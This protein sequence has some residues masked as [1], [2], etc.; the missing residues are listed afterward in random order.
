MPFLL[1]KDLGFFRQMD[2]TPEFILVRGGSVSTRGLMAGNFDYV[3]GL[4][5]VTDAIIRGR[6]PLKV[7]LTTSIIHLS[8][9]AQPNIHSLSDLKGKVIGI[10]APGSNTDLT[11]RKIFK[12]HGLDP[13]RDATLVGVGASRERFVA[14]TSGVVQA[15][16]LSPPFNFRAMKM[17]YRKLADASDYIKWPQGGLGVKEERTRQQSGEV[18]KMVRAALMGLKV[19]LSQR[20]YVLSKM[21]QI[22]HLTQE[23]AAQ[24]YEALQEESVLSGYLTGEAEQTAVTM[25]KEAAGITEDIQ[26][27]RVFDNRF[28]KQ[29]EQELKGWRPQLPK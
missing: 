21:M 20:E 16:V 6:Q 25:L 22:F 8:I 11:V 9:I 24:S 5:S 27:E 1:E 18:I 28:A 12:Q 3:H 7:V 29:A 2:L 14:L 15:T 26:P 19:V 13:G 17:G 4:G 23:E 10:S